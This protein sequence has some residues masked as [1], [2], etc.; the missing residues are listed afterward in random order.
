M[1]KKKAKLWL[2]VVVGAAA[3][4]LSACK[5]K[6]PAPPS[7]QSSDAGSF[8]AEEGRENTGSTTNPPEAAR[9]AEGQAAKSR[10]RPRLEDDYYEYVNWD[11]L[12]ETRI[13]GD[14]SS[15][16]YLY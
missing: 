7:G 5:A 10:L 14:S 6:S 12:S 8:A 11:I 16:S 3:L 13:P 4:A 15:W 1:M 9:A 2:A